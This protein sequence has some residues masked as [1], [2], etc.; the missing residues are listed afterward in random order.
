MDSVILAGSVGREAAW[1]RGIPRPLLPIA[2]T[3]LLEALVAKLDATF[4]GACTICANGRP[5]PIAQHIKMTGSFTTQ[6]GFFEDSV[7]L[8]T[9]GC[10]KAC[11]TRIQSETVFLSGGA[12]WLEDDPRWMLEQHRADENALTVFCTRDPGW[13]GTETENHLRPAGIYCCN[14]IVLDHI[15]PTGY[16]DLKEQ[17]VP[18]LR[19]AGLRVGAVT[20]RGRTCEVSDWTT[21]MRLVSTTLS[22][23]RPVRPG[24]RQL[25]PDIWCGDNVEIAPD[26]RV[27]G[28]ALIGHRCR[29]ERGSVA[30][31][32]VILG[33]DCHVGPGAWL[34]RAV[35]L[36]NAQFRAGASVV[37]RLVPSGP[38]A[39]PG[40]GAAPS[41]RAEVPTASADNRS[42]A[43][44][45]TRTSRRSW[46]RTWALGSALAGLFAWTFWPTLTDLGGVLH[47]NPDYS[48]GLLVPLAALYMIATRRNR[49]AH[50]K[51]NFWPLGV[52]VFG[53]GLAANLYGNL[54]RFSSLENLGL[55]VSANGLVMCAVGRRIFSK[56]WYPLVF[57]L[58]MLPLPHRVHRAA[59]F[60]LQGISASVSANVLETIGIPT[61]RYGHVLETA[62]YRIA[63]AEAC[64]G[65]RLALAFLI[66]TC[67]VVYVIRRPRWQK[68]VVLFSSVPIA[69]ICNTLRVVLSACLYYFGYE[70]LAQGTFHDGAGLVMM[71]I[72]LSLILLEFWLLS[73]LT[74]PRGAVAAIVDRVETRQVASER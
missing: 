8:G 51:A 30:I 9:A 71:P 64:S 1:S 36:D 35:A 3:T 67:V 17:L 13:I 15:R 18:A 39:R 49:W 12:V 14:R 52:V 21:Y 37:D 60:P 61:E 2:G 63:V 27:V 26:A 4:G 66:V 54:F 31:G 56:I 40:S 72:A 16:H 10:L 42:A 68:L 73:N 24:Y 32:P 25:S 57:L 38:L 47:S 44:A 55:V 11:E 19:R 23:N 45:T 6:P 50:L 48:A 59:T 70:S 65:L 20:L 41:E 74:V 53:A 28:P 69:I 34:V 62:G 58:L 43:G 7:P 22:G 33:D 46:V 5:N 29:L